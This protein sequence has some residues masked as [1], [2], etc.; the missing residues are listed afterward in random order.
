MTTISLEAFPDTSL[1]IISAKVCSLPALRR[2]IE[3]SDIAAIDARMILDTIQIVVAACKALAAKSSGSML[4]SKV[5]SEI[6]YRLS[7]S[8]NVL[9]EM[10]ERENLYCR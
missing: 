4:T 2:T 8:G 9:E 6:V 10:Y 5:A 3:L 7:G 1:T